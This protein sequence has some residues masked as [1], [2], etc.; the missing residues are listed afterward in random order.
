[1]LVEE[2]TGWAPMGKYGTRTVIEHGTLS[3]FTCVS[4][5]ML[6]HLTLSVVDVPVIET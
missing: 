2:W 1:M 4:S 5:I 6:A 3:C